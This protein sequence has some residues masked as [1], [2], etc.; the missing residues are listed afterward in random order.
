MKMRIMP[1]DWRRLRGHLPDKQVDLIDY[2]Y[3]LQ[4]L[5]DAVELDMYRKVYNPTKLTEV[6]EAGRTV[7][8]QYV[9]VL[10]P[11]S[12]AAPEGQKSDIELI[13]EDLS[14]TLKILDDERDK[15]RQAFDTKGKGGIYL[16]LQKVKEVLHSY[17]Y[18][19]LT[20]AIGNRKQF[21][22]T[23]IETFSTASLGNLPRI[24]VDEI[25]W[26]D[27]KVYVP[28]DFW[29][30]CD[31]TDNLK[32]NLD[33][34]RNHEFDYVDQDLERRARELAEEY[35]LRVSKG[36]PAIQNI[37][38]E[39]QELMTKPPR[40][41]A[42]EIH[43]MV[44]A[45]FSLAQEMCKGKTLQTFAINSFSRKGLSPKIEKKG[46]LPPLKIDKE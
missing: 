16:S 26:A 2:C 29:R 12:S 1:S 38:S 18:H 3:V 6:L 36:N 9:S 31:L 40:E 43:Y 17:I 10:R 32:F 21:R 7:T 19:S 4:R 45:S 14:Q 11:L 42:T 44:C 28:N 24:D 41:A 5:M 13:T 34:K 25:N 39:L 30:L 20:Q 46:S 33:Y 22:K 37:Q 15:L 35:L 27:I 23:F 8:L